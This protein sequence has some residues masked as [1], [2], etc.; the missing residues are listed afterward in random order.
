MVTQNTT[1]MDMAEASLKGKWGLAIG[2]F[3]IYIAIIS[4]TQIGIHYHHITANLALLILGGPLEY[5]AAVF[6]LALSRNQDTQFEQM[7]KG[8][9]RF[10]VALTAY[11]LMVL[12]TLL[13][14]LLFIIPG[15]IALLSYSMTFFILADHPNM[16][17]LTAIDKSKEMMYGFKLKYFWLNMIYL[18][19]TI[20]C[21]ATLGIG[22]L[23]F[24]PY[25]HVTNAKFYDDIKE[26]V[27]AEEFV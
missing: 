3:I 14:T 13:W 12:F 7:F 25:M 4:G 5:G 6:T 21:I 10:G 18:L 24:I 19:L 1:L 15:I 11:L 26:G 27:I 17:P 23:W 22:F 9:E 8:F 2:T 20:L 16:D